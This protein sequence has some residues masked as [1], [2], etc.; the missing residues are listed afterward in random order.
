MYD[1]SKFY[2]NIR[3]EVPGCPDFLLKRYVIQ[4][5]QEFCRETGYYT[6]SISLTVY[7]EQKDTYFNNR[8]LISTGYVGSNKRP[9]GLRNLHLNGSWYRAALL[10]LSSDVAEFESIYATSGVKYFSFLDTSRIAIF[11]IYDSE[12][13]S[14]ELSVFAEITLEPLE[15]IE[16][17]DEQF[18]RDA[19]D[20]VEGFAV[21]KLAMKPGKEWSSEGVAA[22]GLKRFREA[23]N[24]FKVQRNLAQSGH[25]LRVQPV[26]FI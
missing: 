18:F 2:E 17:V 4:G 11:P 14:G 9:V 6:A 5:I 22:I 26:Q 25:H 7:P 12:F 15:T 1:I 24:D 20:G 10:E 21:Y 13:K 19:R 3:D 8:I 16:K 23:V